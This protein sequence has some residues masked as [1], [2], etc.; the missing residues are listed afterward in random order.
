MRTIDT[1]AHIIPEDCLNLLSEPLARSNMVG[2]MTQITPRLKDMDDCGVEV[3]ALS[4]WLGLLSRDLAT[5]QQFNDSLARTVAQNPDRFIGLAIAPLSEPDRAP[6][7]MERAVK[8]QAVKELGLR[9]VGI[10]SNVNGTNLD[11]TELGPF[12]AKVE[13]LDI[14]IFIHP[15][16]VLG[17]DRLDSYYLTNFI[18]NVTDTAVAAGSIIFGGVF[19]EF[20]KLKIYLA[21][22]GGSCPYIR[23]RWDHGWRAHDTGSK[24]ERPPSEYMKLFYF[25]ALT[26]SAQTLQ[27][28]VDSFGYDRVMLG[29]DYPFD[30]GDMEA[31]GHITEVP[32]LTDAQKEAVLGE[33]AAALFK[34]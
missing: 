22:G 13:E 16:N 32:F 27:F 34:L 28:L 29:S 4:A 31:V 15:A 9:G 23:G 10:G 26:H 20:P 5:A 7:E 33:T 11:A 24:I 14:P 21:H 12:Y 8:E 25:D 2:D 17:A 1:H 30:M 6:A 18:G 3:Q 19:K